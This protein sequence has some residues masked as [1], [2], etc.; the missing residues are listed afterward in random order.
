MTV[1]VQDISCTLFW[2]GS[3]F[4]TKNLNPVTYWSTMALLDRCYFMTPNL[5]CLL[6]HLSPLDKIWA[7]CSIIHGCGTLSGYLHF[8]LPKFLSVSAHELLETRFMQPTGTKSCQ[9]EKVTWLGE[10]WS[11]L[12]PF[13]F[14]RYISWTFTYFTLSYLRLLVV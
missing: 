11:F 8:Y 5:C 7:K 13:L 4:T 1:D 2:L 9:V 6:F 14:F 10:C 12:F 3:I